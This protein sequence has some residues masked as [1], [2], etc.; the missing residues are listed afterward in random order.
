M[1][2]VQAM[3]AERTWDGSQNANWDQKKNWSNDSQPGAAD[4]ALFAAVGSASQPSINSSATIG[5]LVFTG[6]GGWTLSGGSTLTINSSGIESTATGSNTISAAVALG[7]AQTWAISS[8]TLTVS[9]GVSGA[10][11]LTKSGAG[12]LVM[13]GAKAYTGATT[14]SGGVFSINTLA[15]GGSS[16]SIGASG[17]NAS[18]LVFNG[19]T[20]R[21]TGAAGS[22]NR[23][24]TLN[25]A[26]GT[27]EA[28]GT[29][30]V[31]F[32]NTAEIGYGG[33]G[34]RQ[35]TLSGTSLAANTMTSVIGDGSGG[36]TSLVK[37][38]TGTW[39]LGGANTFTGGA[40]VE[41][42][43]LQ[44]GSANRLSAT[45][46]IT[47]NGGVLNISNGQT[48]SGNV[49]FNGGTVTSGTLTKN[50]G[51]FDARSGTAASI[52]SGSA[53][54]TK[55]TSGT[56][57]LSAANTYSG[58]TTV[59]AGVLLFAVGANRLSTSGDITINGGTLNLGGFTQTTTGNVTIAGGVVT[60]GTLTKTGGSH[61]V[62]SGT[63]NATMAG[64][65]GLEKTSASILTLS[66][67]HTYTGATKVSAGT[68]L[69]N[70]NIASSSGVE[71]LSG[72][73]FGGSGI[74]SKISGAGTVAPG[75]SPGILT[76]GSVDGSG[77]LDFNFEFTNAAI[78]GLSQPIFGNATA[79]GNDVLR[80]T[81]ATPFTMALDA[82][83][84][85]TLDFSAVTLTLGDRFQGGFYTD[86]GD[87]L[88]DI[89]AATFNY[90]G[91]G[92]YTMTVAMVQVSTDFGDGVV[93]GYVT[94][95]TVVP[96]P[97][98]MLLFGLSL[99]GLAIANR[100]KKMAKA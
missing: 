74:V 63:I 51:S 73:T 84:V 78:A 56:M 1:M 13:T 6:T 29:G 23:S 39:V 52:L 38:G 21:Y 16:S 14:I 59:E 67:S 17:T 4:T 77:G 76:S 97:A 10:N 68:F 94:E 3:G 44:F 95:F 89:N 61:T 20:L 66:G 65:A 72:A 58:G 69:V 55:T 45:G 5:G 71:V 11:A 42:G 2:T 88:N 15:N 49:V 62:Q 30:A 28:N 98:T 24:F 75:N 96:E 54:L 85:I 53:G 31:T 25:T 91:A 40:T 60:N 8:G 46:A 82:S 93:N 57:T 100:R 81:G 37:N 90:V 7:A 35:L 32:G 26:G 70:G 9:G 50:N 79:S 36:T 83:N 19:G 12:L 92:A 41:S 64:S 48:T 22:T 80:L 87:F 99:G 33:S 27:I 34:T 18:N 43:T 47:V 86:A